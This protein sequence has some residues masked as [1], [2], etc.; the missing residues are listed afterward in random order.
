MLELVPST[1]G[2]FE[3]TVD[4]EKVFS[5]LEVGRFPTEDEIIEVMSN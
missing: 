3:V 2:A 4:G 5:K 1:G